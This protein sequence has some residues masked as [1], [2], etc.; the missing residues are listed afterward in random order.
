MA[1]MEAQIES[2]LEAHLNASEENNRKEM[3]ALF[4]NFLEGPSIAA[5]KG[6]GI[7]GAPP[8]GVQ[9]REHLELPPPP[10]TTS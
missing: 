6:K 4:E 8:L 2:K 1:Q 5:A 7:I 9:P 10:T 3:K